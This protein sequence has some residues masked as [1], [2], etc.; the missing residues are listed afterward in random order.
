MLKIIMGTETVDQFK[1]DGYRFYLTTGDVF[2]AWKQ[3]SWFEE[4]FVKRVIRGI[5]KAEV[6]LGFS[7]RSLETG[8][9]FSVNDL[10]G[11]AKYLILLYI[12]RDK[13]IL[14]KTTM[15][16]NCVPYL[17]E[18]VA[19]YESEGR[20]LIM[21]TN[22]FYW[23]N[24]DKLKSIYYVNWNLTCNSNKEA[25]ETA[26]QH[27]WNYERAHSIDRRAQDLEPSP[28]EES[29]EDF[30]ARLRRVRDARYKSLQEQH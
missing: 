25:R 18:L 3:A 23:W 13:P 30:I 19:L 14:V 26:F 9:G 21:V 20:D 5:D 22:Y 8:E 12:L 29:S 17:E 1:P 27:W 11:G 15:G 24:Y 16:E 6:E 10:S 7:V 4:D 2:D 28:F